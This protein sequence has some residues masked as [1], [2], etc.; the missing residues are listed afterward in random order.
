MARGATVLARSA[1]LFA[2]VN[3]LPAISLAGAG[4]HG[5]DLASAWVQFGEP[6]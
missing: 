5:G 3:L 1:L 4:A 6:D 2:A